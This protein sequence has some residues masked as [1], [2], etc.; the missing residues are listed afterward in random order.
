MRHILI[1]CGIVGVL[2]WI[3]RGTVIPG[4]YT[5]DEADYK[6]AASLGWKANATD[7]PSMS[8]SEFVQTGR[9]WGA[10]SG[11]KT[12]LSETIRASGDVVFYRHWHGPVYIAWLDLVRH[13]AHR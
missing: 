9:T 5:Y 4:P 10:N 12:E 1:L 7:T 11:A 13:F 2:I 6:Y 8:V 3:A